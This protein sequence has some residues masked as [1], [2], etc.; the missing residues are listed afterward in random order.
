[1][2]YNY[3]EERRPQRQPKRIG[4]WGYLAIAASAGA[5][6]KI[7][8]A[9]LKSR[10]KQAKYKSKNQD[11]DDEDID[12]EDDISFELYRGTLKQVLRARKSVIELFDL[13]GCCTLAEFRDVMDQPFEDNDIN[14]VFNKDCKFR[15]RFE[16]GRY[17][18]ISQPPVD[19]TP[20]HAEDIETVETKGDINEEDKS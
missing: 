2:R 12:Q 9:V 15:I 1:M 7:T 3:Y 4:F 19:V 10:E 11:A 8:K 16:D 17:V 18:L 5:A 20:I 6:V 13:Y 14:R